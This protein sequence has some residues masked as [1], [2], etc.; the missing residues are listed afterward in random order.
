M[1][2]QKRSRR[3]GACRVLRASESVDVLDALNGPLGSSPGLGNSLGSDG[4]RVTPDCMPVSTRRFWLLLD[5]AFPRRCSVAPTKHSIPKRF[6]RAYDSAL[7]AKH[8]VVL[9]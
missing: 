9:V 5:V 6:T 4:A 7:P 1:S 8:S 3:P 2:T